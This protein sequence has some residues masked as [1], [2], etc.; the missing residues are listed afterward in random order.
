MYKHLILTTGYAG[1]GDTLS[2]YEFSLKRHLQHQQQ[3]KT[4]LHRLVNTLSEMCASWA[5]VLAVSLDVAHQAKLYLYLCLSGPP[6]VTPQPACN[7]FTFPKIYTN[8]S[9]RIL[10]KSWCVQSS[11]FDFSSYKRSRA[12]RDTT[13]KSQSHHV[14]RCPV[15]LCLLMEYAKLV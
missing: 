12:S 10:W 8:C 9:R 3:Y 15:N 7:R 14:S 4:K 1:Q 11:S 5:W 2:T 6:K 13:V